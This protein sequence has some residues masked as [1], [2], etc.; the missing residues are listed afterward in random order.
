M[1]NL[2]SVVVLLS[3]VA[4]VHLGLESNVKD[5]I[6]LGAIGI[7]SLIPMRALA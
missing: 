1:F 2:I 4:L 7:A 5:F 3:S 6:A